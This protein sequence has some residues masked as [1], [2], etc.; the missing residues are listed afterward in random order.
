[1]RRTVWLLSSVALLPMPANAADGGWGAGGGSVAVDAAARASAAAALTLAQSST[2]QTKNLSDLTNAGVALVNLGGIPM[3]M[4]GVP[5]GVAGLDANRLVPTT[6]IPFG[7]VAKTVADGGMLAATA[8]T[9]NAAVPSSMIGVASGVASLNGSKLLTASQIPFGTGAGTVADGGALAATAATANA[10]IPSSLIGAA[11]GV[12]ALGSNKLLT[13]SQIPFGSGAGTV[14]DGGALAATAATADAAIPSSLI[15]AASGVAALGSNKLLTASQIP[16]GTG[17]GTV[18]DGGALAAAATT[19]NAAIPSSLIGAVSGVAALGSNKLL[20]AAEIPFGTAAGTVADGGALAAITVMANAALP[21]SLIGAASGVAALGSNKLLTAVEIPFGTATGTVADGG[22]LAA[23][24]ATANAA[25]PSSLIGAAS[26]VAA[27]GSNKLLPASQIPFGTAAGTVADGG[28]LAATAATAN[29]AIPSSL[30]GAAS[31]IAALG[32]NKLLTASEM[33]FGTAA[34][35]VADG[36]AL[37][38]TAATANAAIPSSLIGA[39]SGIAALGSNKLLTASE[40]PFGTAAGTVADGGALAVTAATANA[41]IPSSLIGAASGVAALGSN[42]LLTA[43]QIPFGTGAG[44][45]ADGGALAVTAATA[46]AAI[47]SSLIGAASGVAALG[48]NKLLTASQIPFGTGAGTVADGGALAATAAT[49]NAALPSSLIGAASGVAALGSNKLLT[50]SEIPFGTATGTVADGGALAVTAA[51]ANAAIPSSLIGAASG[52]AGLNASKVVPAAQIP[53]GTT[54][55]TVADGGSLA[56]T[57]ATA[58]AAVPSTRLGAASG[59][60]TL[61]ANKLLLSAQVPFGTVSGSV[62]DGGTLAATTTTANAA[63]P[64]TKLGAASGAAQLDANKLVP[65]TQLPF[66]TTTNTVADGGIL[67]TASSRAASAL[68]PS[69]IGS[70][71]VAYNDARITGAA[72]L[73]SPIF[74]G[75]P[76]LATDPAAGDTSKDIVSAGWVSRLL[77]AS[78]GTATAVGSGTDLSQGTITPTGAGSAQSA[79]AIASLAVG[80]IPAS[81]AGAASGLAQLDANKHLVSAQVPFGT[82]TGTVTDGGVFTAAIQNVAATFLTIAKADSGI[83][84]VLG[85]NGVAET[86]G[87]SIAARAGDVWNIADHGADHTVAGDNA[88]IVEALVYAK[89]NPGTHIFF[90]TGSWPLSASSQFTYLVPSSTIIEGADEYASDILFTNDTNTG[91][92]PSGQ[93]CS[94]SETCQY[95]LFAADNSNGRPHDIGVRHI[96]FTG[97]WAGTGYPVASNTPASAFAAQGNGPNMF[98]FDHV[99]NVDIEDTIWEHERAFGIF[100]SGSTDV[101][102]HNDVVR[103]VEADA[104]AVWQSSNISVLG[105]LVEHGNDDCISFHNAD[106]GDPWIQRRAIDIE[107]NTCLDTTAISGLAAKYTVIMGNRMISS[108]G[109]AI[110]ITTMAGGT[111]TTPGT[112]GYNSSQ[113][114]NSSSDNVIIA[115]NVMTDMLARGQVDNYDGANSYIYIDGLSARPGQ[116]G[117][118][119]GEAGFPGSGTAGQAGYKAPTAFAAQDPAPEFFADAQLATTAVGESHSITIAGNTMESDMP[120][121]NGTDARFNSYTDFGQG[122]LVTLKGLLNPT[123]TAAL[124]YGQAIGITVNGGAM[125]DVSIHDNAFEGFTQGIYFAPGVSYT[126][127]DIYHNDFF[128]LS[129]AGVELNSTGINDIT[130]ADNLFDMDPYLHE[131]YRANSSNGYP[132]GWQYDNV[133]CAVR[134]DQGSGL[135]ILRNRVKN[136]SDDICGADP[137]K[138]TGGIYAADNLDYADLQAYPSNSTL[139]SFSKLNLGIGYIHTSGFRVV[140]MYGDPTKTTFGTLFSVPVQAAPAVPSAGFWY[141]GDYVRDTTPTASAPTEG[142][143]RVTMGSGNVLGTDWIA[144]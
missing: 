38:A 131:V 102:V 41:A 122:P 22:A 101:K 61:D 54:S 78:G 15:G 52:V 127:F 43:S 106:S 74:T 117:A 108:R 87:R 135:T 91:N 6:Q 34:G 95:Y 26:G 103:Y 25:I 62:A 70:T 56:T 142:W 141:P 50:V 137:V 42:K 110:S 24:A 16:F 20:A 119:P 140:G 92:V 64:A 17:A 18:A 82:T 94:G 13:A 130:V 35:T 63:L 124:M 84:H 37:A 123:D 8:L 111:S 3:S 65:Y 57:T 81:S 73:A 93:Q 109:D 143:L 31:G 96:R 126:D 1:M 60:A 59:V 129:G 120:S 80:A 134:V 11:S 53:F 125:R 86:F 113:Q 14:A 66:G 76:Q 136:A 99:D 139:N 75:A 10:A 44:T 32:S 90:P 45:V 21:S 33:P 77:S 4:I 128:N 40:M 105:N 71:V 68:Q 55:G 67:A 98:L 72:P 118:I 144:K 28:A 121:F 69:A 9:A 51:T 112:A 47:P 39:A 88:A 49:A 36:G 115:D 107:G 100:V 29:A 27:L 79:A 83:V 12:A 48:S 132:G 46:N 114:G 89:A 85:L 133:D 97:T 58:N 104:I 7:S 138:P 30:I 2:Q 23:T 19:A 116:Y 5:S